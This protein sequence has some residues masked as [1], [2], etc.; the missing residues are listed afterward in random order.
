M[1]WQ[2]P[3][4]EFSA[5]ASADETFHAYARQTYGPDDLMVAYWHLAGS[6]N[7]SIL[8]DLQSG[9]MNGSILRR[10][11]Y[12]DDS[13]LGF[14][15]RYAHLLG[16]D[17]F[18]AFRE[19][20]D[21]LAVLWSSIEKEARHTTDLPYVGG[22]V[23]LYRYLAHKFAWGAE[24]YE[25]YDRASK[26]QYTDP[27]AFRA[28]LFSSAEKLRGYRDVFDEP[29][30]FLQKMHDELGQEKGSILRVRATRDNLMLLADFMEHLA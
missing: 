4:G 15:I 21:R 17:A 27:G 26:L 23:I 1:M 22:P 29:L 8:C 14:F 25:A 16:H 11:A 7:E 6:R 30:A 20:S 2:S 24:L 13:P 19:A 18:A 5:A 12:L 9:E 10:S 3:D 28:L